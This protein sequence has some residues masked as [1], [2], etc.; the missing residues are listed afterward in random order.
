M[1]GNRAA[2][3]LIVVASLVVFSSC[4][5][6]GK[7]DPY[8]EARKK[9]VYEQLIERGIADKAVLSVMRA[10]PRHLFVPSH[11]MDQAYEDYPLPIGYGQTISQPYIVALMTE[12]AAIGPSF[13][14]LEIGTGSG[15]QAA[16]LSLLAKEV[17][18]VEIRAALAEEA[19]KRLANLG[20]RNVRVAAGDGYFGWPEAAPFDAIIITC[21]A[22]HIPQPLLGQL[23]EGGRLVL[24]LGSTLY[25]QTLT[26]VTKKGNDFEVKH[27]IPVSFVPMT[28]EMEK[29]R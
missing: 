9:M 21:A 13:T 28:G 18:T 29:K 2:S 25:F 23:K 5:S 17:Y 8:P 7:D 22:N 4:V 1:L 20:Y 3:L 15:Y 11:V 12:L 10:V 26:L 24:P 6:A 27:L 14:V 16:V 19:K